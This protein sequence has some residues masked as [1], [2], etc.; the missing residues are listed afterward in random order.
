V[1]AYLEDVAPDGRV[2]YLGEGQ[3]RALH[4][5]VSEAAPPYPVIGPYHTFHRADGA[6]LVPGTPTEL[7]FALHP[8]SVRLEAGHRLRVAV[9]GADSDT[10]ARI[11][12]EGPL[13]LEVH[14]GGAYPSRIAL[15]IGSP[16]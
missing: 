3:L 9:A 2:T 10:F 16:R 8:L 5:A 7:T 6:P 11:P 1:F 4:R 14:H 12:A 13:E 15:P